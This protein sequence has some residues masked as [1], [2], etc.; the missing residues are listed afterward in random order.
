M[1][2]IDGDYPMAL[3]VRMNRD[4][5]LPIDQVRS[6]PD[7]PGSRPD[8][9]DAETMASLPEM[10]RGGV[11]AALVKV[12]VDQHRDGAPMP[13]GPRSDELSYA[14]GQGQMAYYR[15]L[16]TRGEAR[17][18]R[19]SSDV[20]DHMRQWESAEFYDDLPVGFFL[21]MEGADP[22]LWPAQV[23]EWYADGLRV[24]SLG[25]YGPSRYGHGTGTGTEGGL[26]D[27]GPE[28]LREMDTLGMILDVTHTSDETVRQALDIFTGPVLASHQNC[29]ALV[30]GER[31]MSDD[32]LKRSIERGAVIGASMDTWMLTRNVEKDWSGQ[33]PQKRTDLF[34]PE[35]VTLEDV[36]DHIEHV[37]ELAG[38]A[39]HAAIGGDTDGQGGAV[40]APHD[41]DTV[42]DYQKIAVILGERGWE[43]ADIENVMWRNW[44]RYFEE[45]LPS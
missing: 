14:L 43:T 22:I 23:H 29:R 25:H 36:V 12:V 8:R 21:G 41:V 5:T 4:L 19:T 40:G 31:Q 13:G 20:R 11:A 1:L 45:F 32:L 10:R 33:T 6:A 39:L 7:L 24:I 3:A 34:K 17:I 15:I 38:D 35:D 16:E 9:A 44:Q 2:I 30:P 26:F 18:L 37:C 42:A 27:G 28:L